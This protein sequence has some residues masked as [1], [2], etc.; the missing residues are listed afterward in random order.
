MSILVNYAI[1]E[2][3]SRVM[4]A[5]R[6]EKTAKTSA[7][8]LLY[9]IEAPFSVIGMFKFDASAYSV[10]TSALAKIE[11]ACRSAEKKNK[12]GLLAESN[13]KSLPGAFEK[14]KGHCTALGLVLSAKAAQRGL[15]LAKSPTSTYAQ[16]GEL[17]TDL[18][19]R[20][21]D[22]WRATC[23]CMSPSR[24]ENYMK[25][26]SHCLEKRSPKHSPAQPTILQKRESAFR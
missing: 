23:F 1:W 12:D 10:F 7:T 16:L 26:K 22:D 5:A 24:K 18:N 9:S 6:R 13:R 14:I 11:A 8:K 25:L 20:I 4:A 21:H 17:V 15:E 2:S 19:R 3:N